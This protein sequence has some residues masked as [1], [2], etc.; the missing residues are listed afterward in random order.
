MQ[1]TW[2]THPNIL[3]WRIPWTEEAGRLQ[4]MESQRV[5]QN[6]VTNTFTFFSRLNSQKGR[7]LT[8]K[9][10]WP[11]NKMKRERDLF[12]PWASMWGHREKVG[13]YKT[14]RELSPETQLASTLIGTCQ[15][16]ETWEKFCSLSHPVYGL[17]LQQPEQTKTLACIYIMRLR[18]S[19]VA[20]VSLEICYFYYLSL[21]K[22]MSLL[23]QQ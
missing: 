23:T 6:W 14:G 11:Y 9:N 19:P 8:L 12:L 21:E 3:A 5:G 2:V 13:V 16:S 18:L 10:L 15:C 20:Q 22:V 17:L 7:V 4:P 1:E